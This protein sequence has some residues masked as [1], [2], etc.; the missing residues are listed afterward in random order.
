MLRAV[1]YLRPGAWGELIDNPDLQVGL[2]A[3][4]SYDPDGARRA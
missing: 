1:G 3:L 4:G 2:F